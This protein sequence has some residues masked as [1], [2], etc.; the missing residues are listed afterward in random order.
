MKLQEITKIRI[1]IMKSQEITINLKKLKKIKKSEE[2][3]INRKKSKK[4][5]EISRN[6]SESKEIVRNN[7]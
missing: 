6:N 5:Q 7:N 1:H 4:L 2:I 3:T